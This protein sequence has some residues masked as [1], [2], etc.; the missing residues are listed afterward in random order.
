ML[1]QDSSLRFEL[2][3]IYY[4]TERFSSQAGGANPE[5]ARRCKFLEERAELEKIAR[6]LDAEL[7]TIK[8][9][10]F[11]YLCPVTGLRVQGWLDDDLTVDDNT[12]VTITCTACRQ[13]HLVNRTGK[14]FGGDLEP[15]R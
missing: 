3:Q 15:G 14:V 6:D 10:T 4:G 5:I 12:Y 9:D 11:I 8:G 1:Q 2:D 13:L 7:N